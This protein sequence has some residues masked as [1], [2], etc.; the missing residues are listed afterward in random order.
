MRLDNWTSK[1]YV[2][3]IRKWMHMKTITTYLFGIYFEIY[4]LEKVWFFNYICCFVER[5]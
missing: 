4:C 5:I 2:K 1:L 3:V